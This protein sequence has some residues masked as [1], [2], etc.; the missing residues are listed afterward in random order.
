MKVPSPNTGATP[1]P[2]PTSP[3][4]KPSTTKTGCAYRAWYYNLVLVAR[5][6]NRTTQELNAALPSHEDGVNE[7]L[8]KAFGKVV[9]NLEKTAVK[10]EQE[11]KE[12]DGK[13][14]RRYDIRKLYGYEPEL[15]WN[16]LER[17]CVLAVRDEELDEFFNTFFSGGM[18]RGMKGSVSPL[19]DEYAILKGLRG[20]HPL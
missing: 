12:G 7:L 19:G 16:S 8:K 15:F 20:D 14:I 3:T 18:S 9:D 10:D 17:F 6:F 4:P 2:E 1:R 13:Q 11:M 5:I